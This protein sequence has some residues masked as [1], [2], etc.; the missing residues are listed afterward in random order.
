MG[1]YLP[2]HS[3]VFSFVLWNGSSSFHSLRTWPKQPSCRFFREQKLFNCEI[4]VS[5]GWVG[6]KLLWVAAVLY[7]CSLC[8]LWQKLYKM[9]SVLFHLNEKRGKPPILC[10]TVN[11]ISQ[12]LQDFLQWDLEEHCRKERKV[13]AIK[14]LSMPA[15]M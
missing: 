15:L 13:K 2:K 3:A 4:W 5:A 1:T 7:N 9:A 11:V 12:A 8:W 10:N 6:I 14:L